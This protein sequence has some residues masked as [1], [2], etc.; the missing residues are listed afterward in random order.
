MSWPTTSRFRCDWSLVHPA[1]VSGVS[2]LK[3]MLVCQVWHITHEAMPLVVP[4]RS[5]MKTVSTLSR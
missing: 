3:R 4:P 5:S 2:R 1:A